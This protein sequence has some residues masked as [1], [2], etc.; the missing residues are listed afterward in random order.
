MGMNTA[1][2]ET[3]VDIARIL[4][5][6]E[7]VI[8]LLAELTEKLF[9]IVAG[10]SVRYDLLDNEERLWSRIV[11]RGG[12]PERPELGAITRLK[13]KELIEQVLVEGRYILSI[14]IGFGDTV[15]GRFVIERKETK[16]TDEE[17]DVLKDCAT[18][19]TLG[20]RT[21]P[22]DLPPKPRRPFDD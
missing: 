13:T 21:R 5:R 15:S 8:N 14:P 11:G 2:L 19:L 3:F 16:F 18:L 6:K 22:L 17:I 9:M 12:K 20:L 10:D 7:P 4:R 1:Q